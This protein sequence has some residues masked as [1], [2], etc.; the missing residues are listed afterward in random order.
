ME[1]HRLDLVN[2]GV[3]SF[4][5]LAERKDENFLVIN[6]QRNRLTSF[7]F[8]G[9]HPYL[10]E[11]HLQYNRI[12]SFRGLT[13]QASLRSL[14]LQGCPVACHPYY[15]LMALLTIGFG[16]E[17][18]DGLPITPQ[19]RHVAKALGKRA[20]LAVSYGWLLDL[21]PRTS[22][23]Y[24]AIIDEFRRLR[25]DEYKRTQSSRLPS[26]KAVLA[27]LDRTRSQRGYN[28]AAELQLTEREKT[29]TRLTRRV[30]QLECQLAASPSAHAVPLL[31]PTEDAVG[32][33]DNNRASSSSGLFSATEL[34]LMDK[35]SFLHGIQLR[36]NLGREQG[37]FHRVC[38]QIDHETLTAESFLSRERL[39]Q[40]TL[41]SLRVRHV[42]PLT[43]AA[44]D[45]T[46]GT[47]ELRFDSLPLLQTVYKALFLLS[48]RP[49]P[50]L[51]VTTQG[52]LQEVENVRRRSPKALT[53]STS[54]LTSF[55]FSEG[56]PSISW[57]TTSEHPANSATACALTSTTP[58]SNVERGA[59]AAQ[60]LETL[61]NVT[62]VP[63]LPAAC[64][65]PNAAGQ[66]HS[67]YSMKATRKSHTAAAV[68]KDKCAPETL[69]VASHAFGSSAAQVDGAVPKSTRAG[70]T[71]AF[72]AAESE[73]LASLVFK[74]TSSESVVFESDAEDQ[75][76]ASEEGIAVPGVE[77]SAAALPRIPPLVP[78]NA[79]RPAGHAKAPAPL[80][81]PPRQTQARRTSAT[82]SVSG[83]QV[84]SGTD[85]AAAPG[86]PVL[87][88][89]GSFGTSGAASQKSSV[90]FDGRRKEKQT[91][92]VSFQVT[93]SN[94]GSAT[95]NTARSSA[96][97]SA[98]P[99]ISSRF[100]SL[101]IDSDSDS[102]H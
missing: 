86:S 94:G 76:R 29:I 37:D 5:G 24:D 96:K 58:A 54:P 84:R 82:S 38:L 72:P 20:A 80:R 11:V 7:E 12:E 100:R 68:A 97:D 33:L 30:A 4:E 66:S 95:A 56:G 47:V 1:Y 75:S 10:I 18:V 90:V 88:S 77:E 21:H 81:V 32:V 45:A 60:H 22:A 16:L 46:G 2:Q 99:E 65:G 35:M 98:Q 26:V 69:G 9:T 91:S 39:V 83:V 23:E 64:S 44:A 87:T 6:L 31:P 41:R 8:F 48:A 3:E 53:S 14:H 73:E 15:R 89:V 13:R 78:A 74:T 25:R 43:L 17:D 57:F 93:M 28:T 34:A 36:H 50:P 71:K 102:N 19:E 101:L 40:L 92:S 27:N 79:A 61:D 62:D 55:A 85:K 59:P 51:S 52:E 42:R 49:V 63:P 67:D 70:A